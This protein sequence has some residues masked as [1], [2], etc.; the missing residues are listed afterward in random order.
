MKDQL[1][2]TPIAHIHTDM[3]DKFGIP[4][5]SGIVK[6]LRGRVIF[7]QEYRDINAFKRIDE[8]SH[9]WLIWGFSANKER[10]DVF[11]ATARP[12]MLGG[13][14]HVGVF[15]CR[16]PYRPNPIGLSLV[17]FEGLEDIPGV[18][19]VLT[20][21]GID[22]LDGT[23][24]Y[25]IKPYLP[26][27]EAIPEASNGFARDT[28]V[29]ELTVDCPPELL[30]IISPESRDTLM[31]LLTNDPRPHYQHDSERVYKLSF[32]TYTIAFKVDKNLLTV[33]SVSPC[34]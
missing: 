23:P 29:G 24:I 34:K 31:A 18:G 21:S 15:A 22:M 12:P 8:Y 14:E 27:V 16:T 5:Q 3:T 1:L 25:D 13:N 33:V 30:S 6:E 17:R 10:D 4:R 19:P 7:E 20:V 9:L 32:Q 2:L 11:H 26:Y 28:T